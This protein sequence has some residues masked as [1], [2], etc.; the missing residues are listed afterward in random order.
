MPADERRELAKPLGYDKVEDV[1]PEELAALVEG[2]QV[3]R[4]MKILNKATILVSPGKPRKIARKSATAITFLLIVKA[5]RPDLLATVR[6]N[7]VSADDLPP[8]RP[9]NS[10]TSRSDA[11]YEWLLKA[12]FVV[13]TE[14]EDPKPNT[15]PRGKRNIPAAT[16][17][18]IGPDPNDGLKQLLR[19]LTVQLCLDGNADDLQYRIQYCF[20]SKNPVYLVVTREQ[21]KQLGLR[22]LQDELPY[23]IVF[24]REGSATPSCSACIEEEGMLVEY[25][26]QLLVAVDDKKHMQGGQN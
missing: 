9:H 16:G 3:M 18:E 11:V 6:P 13:P 21:Y 7:I 25:L 2:A 23:L 10:V 5:I 20:E 1:A 14:Y 15:R 4:V 24:I 26:Y 22:A 8:M 19:N 17:V 12:C